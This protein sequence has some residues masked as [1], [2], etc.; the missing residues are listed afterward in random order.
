MRLIPPSPSGWQI[1]ERVNFGK[2]VA[3]VLAVVAF[4]LGFINIW[5]ML[6]ILALSSPTVFLKLRE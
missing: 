2:L 3:G 6:A 1:P 5:I 4:G